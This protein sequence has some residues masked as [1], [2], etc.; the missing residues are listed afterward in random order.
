MSSKD[1]KSLDKELNKKFCKCVRTVKY[2]QTIKKGIQY[3][4]C[5]KSIYKNRGFEVPKGVIK[6]PP[7]LS[8]TMPTI[9]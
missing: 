7:P 9:P 4:I 3:P 1:K 8:H 5:M 2:I 6:R